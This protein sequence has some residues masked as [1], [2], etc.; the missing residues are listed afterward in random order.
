MMPDSIDFT[1]FSCACSCMQAVLA[2]SAPARLAAVLHD[3]QHNI[4]DR[5]DTLATHTCIPDIPPALSLLILG[6]FFM[7]L[8]LLAYFSVFRDSSR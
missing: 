4:R 5:A 1:L 7:S 8:A 3:R 2:K 6:L